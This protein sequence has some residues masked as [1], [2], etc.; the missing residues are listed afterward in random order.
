MSGFVDRLNKAVRPGAESEY[1]D[2]DGAIL[3]ILDAELA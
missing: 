3:A 2:V 1:I